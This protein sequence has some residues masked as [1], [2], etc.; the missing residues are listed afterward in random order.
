MNKFNA[1]RLATT[2]DQLVRL[3][4]H[5]L[6]FDPISDTTTYR[7]F[8]LVQLQLDQYEDGE[9]NDLAGQVRYAKSFAKRAYFLT[10]AEDKDE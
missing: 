2:Y 8:C 3:L 5:G 6:N 1:L 4:P 9:D 10:P 7:L